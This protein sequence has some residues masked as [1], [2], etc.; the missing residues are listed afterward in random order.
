MENTLRFFQA[1]Y[2]TSLFFFSFHF[3]FSVCGTAT[4][5]YFIIILPRPPNASRLLI[6]SY[7]NHR[8]KFSSS[9]RLLLSDRLVSAHHFFFLLA[10]E[11]PTAQE[12]IRKE[13]TSKLAFQT[14]KRP[15]A[16]AP[17]QVL[18]PVGAAH[19]RCSHLGWLL[20]TPLIARPSS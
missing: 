14:K 2:L 17:K 9:A 15:P 12:P 18:I 11:P 4:C 20:F 13:N 8:Q 6:A 7:S 16:R 19:T 3:S 5:Q 1:W 10:L